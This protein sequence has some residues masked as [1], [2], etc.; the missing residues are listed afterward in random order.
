MNPAAKNI[1][2]PAGELRIEAANVQMLLIAPDAK[3][4]GY[5]PKSRK[6]L[7]V[8]PDSAYYEDALLAYDSGRVDPNTTQTI[9]VRRPAPGNYRLLISPGTAADGE[10]YEILVHLY[11]S[12]GTEASVVRISGQANRG[13]PTAFELELEGSPPRTVLLKARRPVH[14]PKP[15]ERQLG[16]RL[17]RRD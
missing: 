7:R 4:T 16:G 14:A 6:V 13:A 15:H 17:S 11:R 3:E 2:Q 5:D 10:E 8:I 1:S 12:D 9:D